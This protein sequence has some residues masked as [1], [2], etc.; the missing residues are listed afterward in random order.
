MT[1]P[2]LIKCQQA[3]MAP[4]ALCH[5]DQA[6][7][8]LQA[9]YQQDTANAKLRIVRKKLQVGWCVEVPQASP[10]LDATFQLIQTTTKSLRYRTAALDQLN[11]DLNHAVEQ[12]G[13]SDDLASDRSTF[14]VEMQETATILHQATSRSLVLMDEVGRGTSVQDGLAI[15]QAVR[16]CFGV[17]ISLVGRCDIYITFVVEDLLTRH[18]RLLF[19]THFTELG[20]SMAPSSPVAYHHMQV[21]VDGGSLVF[22]HRVVPGVASA[23]YGIEVAALAGCPAHV[24]DRAKALVSQQ[25]QST[26]GLRQDENGLTI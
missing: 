6:I 22:S 19:A 4:K 20:R 13:A 25:Q 24:V 26:V 21:V 17:Y 9:R 23:S 12:V 11:L 1:S 2:L 14:M 15:A 18:T 8:T 10:V 16:Y 3:L 5:E 7:S